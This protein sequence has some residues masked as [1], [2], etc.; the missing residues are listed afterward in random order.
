MQRRVFSAYEL[1]VSMISDRET[2][3]IAELWKRICTRYEISIKS[4]FA[5]H[6]KTDDQTENANKVMKN[7]LRAYVKYAQNDWINYLSDAKFAANNHVNVFTEMTFFFV[8]HE[9]HSRSEAESSHHYDESRKAEIQKAD[10]IIQRQEKMTKW[11]RENLIW[12]QTKQAHHVNKTRQSHSEYKVDDMMYVNVKDFFSKRLSRSLIF[13]NVESWKII[14]VIDN[15]TYEVKVSEHLKA[16]ELTSIFHSWKLHLAS[17]NS[18]FD[19]IESSESSVMI[20]DLQNK[21]SHEEYELLD[22]VNC[23]KFMKHDL[24]YKA[25]YIDNWNQ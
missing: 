1:S 12:A 7:H 25:T 11:I 21:E 13:K 9:Y 22:I 24:Q 4:F 19:Q 20:F 17:N 6:S 10:E 8:D 5:H 16:A 15:K 14:R 3:L 2:Q 23:R 18:F